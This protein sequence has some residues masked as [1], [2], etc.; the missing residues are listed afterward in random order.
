MTED[1]EEINRKQM[2]Q[3]GILVTGIWGESHFT[4]PKIQYKMEYVIRMLA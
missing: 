1:D 4:Y 3:I 2:K